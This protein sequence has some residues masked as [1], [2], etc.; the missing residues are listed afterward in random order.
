MCAGS[1]CQTVHTPTP[2]SLLLLKGTRWMHLGSPKQ[3]I[4]KL[5]VGWVGIKNCW[6]EDGLES[7]WLVAP[8]VHGQPTIHSSHAVVDLQSWEHGSLL[9]HPLSSHLI[10]PSYMNASMPNRRQLVVGSRWLLR[11]HTGLH[12]QILLGQIRGFSFQPP[13]LLPSSFSHLYWSLWGFV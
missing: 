7:F 3:I 13:N 6:L 4:K 8:S 1:V 5:S 11:N 9:I 10:W 2:S 12:I